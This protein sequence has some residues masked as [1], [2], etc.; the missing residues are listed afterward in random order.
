MNCLFNY[1]VE[2]NLSRH[3]GIRGFQTIG[4]KFFQCSEVYGRRSGHLGNLTNFLVVKEFRMF[5]HIS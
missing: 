4:M 3:I 5:T 2:Q 1:T